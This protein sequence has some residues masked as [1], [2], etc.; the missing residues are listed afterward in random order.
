MATPIFDHAPEVAWEHTEDMPHAIFVFAGQAAEQR[1]S[2]QDVERV[3]LGWPMRKTST[4]KAEIEEFFRL[5]GRVRD[6]FYVRIP[7]APQ[8]EGVS[9][10]TSISG[11]TGFVL[12]TSG[13]NSRDYPVAT[14]T[15]TV[16]EDGSPTTTTVTALPDDRKFVLDTAPTSGTAM[17]VDYH[18]Y[19]LVRLEEPFRWRGLA[20]DFF[21]TVAAFREV[22]A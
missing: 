18:T 7:R 21:E 15:F 14:A 2:L 20:P 19:R 4:E 1:A 12:P 9:L 5:R 13:N 16:Y 17:T 11:Q 6:A 10:G 8:E 22:P 3:R